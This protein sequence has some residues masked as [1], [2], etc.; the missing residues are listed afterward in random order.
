MSTKPLILIVEDSLTQAKQIAA[1]VANCGAQALIADNGLDALIMTD[2]EH[3]LL[4]ILDVHL[5]KMD[6]YQVCHRLK[7]DP[8]T[9]NIPVIMLTS[10]DSADATIHGLDVGAD[11][12][13]PKD[14]YAM[15]NLAIAI[16]S[17]LGVK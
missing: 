16:I 10:A 4:I 11:D 17:F 5:P 15:D 8:N 1:C 3:P 2:Q 14:I 12:Y 9:T 13:I 7:R 6:G